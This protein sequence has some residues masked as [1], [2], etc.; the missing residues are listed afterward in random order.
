[1]DGIE[2]IKKALAYKYGHLSENTEDANA[3][4]EDHVVSATSKSNPPFFCYSILF[5]CFLQIYIL[6][7]PID[8]HL[9]A[10]LYIFFAVSF[11]ENQYYL[12]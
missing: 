10:F 7:V 3:Q 5:S 2:E 11:I 6:R 1:M 8:L 4:I 12:L 9:R